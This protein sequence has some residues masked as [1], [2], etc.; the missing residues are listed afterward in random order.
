LRGEGEEMSQAEEQPSEAPD[1][2]E[3]IQRLLDD[4]LEAVAGTPQEDTLKEIR[5]QMF[6]VLGTIEAGKVNPGSQS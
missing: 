6:G 2:P 1:D 3:K 5:A 4:L